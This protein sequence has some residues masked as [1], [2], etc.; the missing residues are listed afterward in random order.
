MSA[1]E[2]RM[3]RV[4]AIVSV[5]IPCYGQAYFL[6]EAIESVLAQTHPAEIVVVDDGSPDNV[7]EVAA[8]YPSVHCL[9]QENQGLAQARNAGFAAARGEFIIFLDADDRLSLTAVEAHLRCFAENPGAGFVVGDIDHIA[10]DGSYLDSPRWPAL[11]ANYYE[12]LL[13]VNHVANTIAVMFRREVI[14]E[15]EGFDKSCTPA[16][17]Y[18]LLLKAARLF[19]SAH[20]ANLVAQYRRYSTSLSRHGVVMLR[21]MDRIMKLEWSKVKGDHNLE[22]A[23]REGVRYWQDHFGRVGLKEL[24][25]RITRGHL[26]E[27][28]GTL[29]GLVKY[30]GGQLL[31][32]P[33]RYR[34]RI[35]RKIRA[36]FGDR[37]GDSVVEPENSSPAK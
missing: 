25:A 8:R 6:P 4:E 7:A 20:H 10:A 29:I 1:P 24:Y 35:V 30:T 2:F 26:L 9:R 21:A 17:D 32:L 12:E 36:R 37:R 27:A 31:L 18:H 28:T 34:R 11:R 13:R 15:V 33:W 3:A 14:A 16:E 5:V 19:P 23:H 22:L